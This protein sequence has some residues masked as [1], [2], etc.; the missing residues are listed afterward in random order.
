MRQ[1]KKY[2]RMFQKFFSDILYK[3]LGNFIYG[4]NDE[5]L[6]LSDLLSGKLELTNIHLKQSVIDLIDIPCRLNFGCVGYFKINLPLLYFMKNPINIY[7][8]DVII[9]L[10]TIPSKYF[11]DKLYKEKYI[12][13]KK[14]LLLSSEY[15]AIVCSAEGGVIWQMILSLINNI[16]ITIKNVHIRIE[17]F[18]SNPSN[19]FSLGIKIEELFLNMPKE[20]L[21]FNRDGYYTK[22]KELVSNTMI[23]MITVK[24]L[25]FYMDSLDMKK[26]TNKKYF[27]KF[28]DIFINYCNMDE[29]NYPEINM[30]SNYTNDSKNIKKVHMNCEI[31]NMNNFKRNRKNKKNKSKHNNH[32][33]NNKINNNTKK[34]F[35]K[36]KNKRS[37]QQNLESF[38]NIIKSIKKS[39]YYVCKNDNNINKMDK[40][41]QRILLLNDTISAKKKKIK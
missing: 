29:R 28:R 35:K 3:I 11:D 19:C 15:R 24:R 7:M 34:L 25:A 2:V 26:I 30:K 41:N 16:N 33:N 17:D 38:L 6:A 27:N 40:I 13:N 32:K 37:N 21:P 8:E 5:E 12:E 36:K 10:S 9:V 39:S 1:I 4:L 18:T 14:N 20:G 31:Q 22:K 23:N